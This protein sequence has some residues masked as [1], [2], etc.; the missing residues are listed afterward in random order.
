MWLAA[1]NPTCGCRRITGE[2]AG[3]APQGGALDRVAILKEAGIDPA[4]RR[5]GPS[6]NE[7]LKTQAA[8]IL[9]VDFFHAETI[10]LA[11]LYCLAAGAT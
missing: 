4:P 3:L 2:L 7:F 6:W 11:R 1:G 8:G 10:T 5:S 9:A